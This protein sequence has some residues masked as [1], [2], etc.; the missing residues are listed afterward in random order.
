MWRNVSI[1]DKSGILTLIDDIEIANNIP[2]G[3]PIPWPLAKPPAGYLACNGQTFNK[4]T[5]PKLAIAY[6]S[7]KLPDLRGKFIR[8]FDYGRGVDSGRTIL[9][10][11]N[12]NSLLSGTGHG[13]Y[14]YEAK[15]YT[16]MFY[17]GFNSGSNNQ[18][19]QRMWQQTEGKNGNETRP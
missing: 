2:V 3:S 10:P 16:E 19:D 14:N 17:G 11:Q 8:G 13:F 15:G 12:G 18:I 4:T 7:G 6:P 5:Y 1:P 9:S